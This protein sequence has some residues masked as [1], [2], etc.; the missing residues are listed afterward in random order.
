MRTSDSDLFAELEEIQDA[1]RFA[2]LEDIRYDIMN[3]AEYVMRDE[4]GEHWKLGEHHKEWYSILLSAVSGVVDVSNIT[5]GGEP[6]LAAGTPAAMNVE[7]MAPREHGKTS[8]IQCFLLFILGHNPNIRIKYVTGADNLATDV[9]GQVKKNIENNERF[10]EVF[11]HIKSRHGGTWTGHELEIERDAAADLGI[12]DATLQAFGVTASATGG[13]ADIIIFDDMIGSREA[14]QEPGR[15]EKIE[16]LFW[17]DWMNI[18]GNCHIVIG[19][20]WTPTDIH[21]QLLNDPTWLSWKKPAIVDGKS[22]WPERWPLDALA[23]RKAKIKETAFDLQFMLRGLRQEQT[24]WTQDM[25]DKCLRPDLMM[26]QVPLPAKKVVCGFDP[27]ASLKTSGSF[28][29]AIA[30]SLDETGGKTIID[31]QR[32]RLRPKDMAAVV[33]EMDKRHHFDMLLVENNATQSAFVD[34]V[35][36]ISQQED[37]KL[38]EKIVEQFTGTK[39]WNPELGLQRI[40]MDMSNGKWNFPFSGDHSDPLHS[41]GICSLIDEMLHFPYEN[42]TTDLIMSLWLADCAIEKASLFGNVESVTSAKKWKSGW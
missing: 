14:I 1:I 11:P 28:S 27:A 29:C 23:A 39:K 8:T 20:P 36:L 17:T 2:E 42:D 13:R 5:V 32:H 15:L 21:M 12:K 33:V 34:L 26:G 3:F 31:I 18:G 37:T 6:V 16:R 10:K 24:W 41:C 35:S 7:I 38:H 25:I 4:K 40:I 9:V 19:T 30:V 22:L